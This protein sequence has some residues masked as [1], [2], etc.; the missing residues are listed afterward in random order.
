MVALLTSEQLKVMVVLDDE[1]KA[2]MTK[3]ELVKQKL[4]RE[5]NVVF[6][7]DAFDSPQPNEADIEDLLDPA[8][9]E[10]LVN[11]SYKDELKGKPVKLNAKIP[12]I[13]KRYEDAFTTAGLE[14]YKTRPARLLLRK[15]ASDPASIMT[16]LTTERFERLFAKISEQLRRHMA[17]PAKPFS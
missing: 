15:M 17:R 7:T 13:V 9:Y 2:R 6:V 1:S 5:E 11:E 12:R 8:V 10:V 16:P 14:F 4:I 3:D